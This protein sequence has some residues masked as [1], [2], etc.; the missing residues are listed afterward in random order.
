MEAS[1]E[2][3]EAQLKLW[4]LKIHDL[5]AGTQAPGTRTRFDDLMDIDE[6]KALC[7]IAQSKFDDFTAAGD[8]E[9]TRLKAGL[10][11]AWDELAAAF[12][13]RKA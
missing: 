2:Q 12:K 13:A 10:K 3:M 6:L 1:V 9:R 8:T 11:G 4:S 7:A 5:T